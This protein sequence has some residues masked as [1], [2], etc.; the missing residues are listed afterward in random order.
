MD[1]VVSTNLNNNNKLN[2]IFDNKLKLG[3]NYIM[4]DNNIKHPQPVVSFNL[5][6]ANGLCVKYASG[7]TYLWVS[8][9]SNAIIK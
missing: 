3:Y 8:G 6:K 1:H 5:I 2:D 7:M 9:A 4:G